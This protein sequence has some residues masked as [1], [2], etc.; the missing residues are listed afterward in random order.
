M[1]KVLTVLISCLVP[2]SILHAG[3]LDLIGTIGFGPA[4]L[5]YTDGAGRAY[6]STAVN[7]DLKSYIP[8]SR[9]RLDLVVRSEQKL[10]I[11]PYREDEFGVNYTQ[12]LPQRYK[13]DTCYSVYGN[14]GRYSDQVFDLA[15]HRSTRFGANVLFA[16]VEHCNVLGGIEVYARDV[17]A[18]SSGY[19]T[20]TLSLTGDYTLQN[21]DLIDSALRLVTFNH[22]TAAFD[23]RQAHLAAGWNRQLSPNRKIRAQWNYDQ[24][25]SDVSGAMDLRRHKIA[26]WYNSSAGSKSIQY[27]GYGTVLQYPNASNADYKALNL[28]CLTSSSNAGGTKGVN[29]HSMDFTYHMYQSPAPGYLDYSWVYMRTL[30]QRLNL[31]KYIDNTL[32]VRRFQ[33]T[34]TVKYQHFYDDQVGC[35]ILYSDFFKGS[36]KAGIL[37]GFRFFDDPNASTNANPDDDGLLN[38]PLSYVL[39]GLRASGT[40]YFS[41][42]CRLDLEATY[43]E[44]VNWRAQPNHTSSDEFIF[45]GT[46]SLRL[47]R[48]CT[49]LMNAGIGQQVNDLG[50]AAS[51][52]YYRSISTLVTYSF[53]RSGAEQ[54]S[55][56]P[57]HGN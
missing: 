12:V 22:Q 50:P 16:P 21:H 2:C 3:N 45:N 7:V 30:P 24:V 53:D 13:Q 25:Q 48:V 52:Q 46:Y 26:A 33:N 54:L 29:T 49:F 43:K 10:L 55:G 20:Q 14:M 44:I 40:Y 42:K 51:G 47:T 4:L 18:P 35:G 17:K 37:T 8:F 15:N 41:L 31:S 1:R 32:F 36:V 11:T 39:Y 9:S 34:A 5:S 57:S 28:G 27:R 6:K 19:G 23:H 38:N 56:G